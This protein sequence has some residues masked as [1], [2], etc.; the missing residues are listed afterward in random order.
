M[1]SI[2]WDT[3]KLPGQSPIPPSPGQ[4]TP[5]PAGPVDNP[6]VSA[7]V[8]LDQLQLRNNETVL[9]RVADVLQ[10]GGAGPELVLDIRGRSLLVQ[11]SIGNS[12][13][14]VGDW[15]RI[16][17]AGNELQLL[18]KL[19]Q[20]PDAGIAKALAQRLPWQQSLQTGLSVLFQSLAGGV[21]PDPTPGQLPS[22]VTATPLPEAA[23]QALSQLIARFP[24]STGV[25]PGAGSSSGAPEQVR[26]WLSESGLF[27]EARLARAQD[28]PPADL[29]LALMRV[30]ASL[31]SQQGQ[32]P[33]HFMR[34]RAASSPELL[35]APLQFPRL[36][37]APATST[38]A[39]S[40]PVNTGQLLKLLAGMLN[41]ITVNQLHSQVL[42][43]R[44]GGD[45]PA[46]TSTLLVELPWLTPQQEPRVAQLRI[47]Q[48]EREQKQ[49]AGS[50]KT[51]VSEWRLTLAMDLDE[52]GPLHFDLALRQQTVSASIW[53]EHQA[54][55]RR[56]NEQLPLLRRSLS[57]LGLEVTELE[58][59][60]G[61]PP[62]I[63]TRL[64]HRLVDT[65]A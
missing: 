61:T 39:A 58:C 14:A 49:Q 41:R 23:R 48:H 43:A 10:R 29:K 56:V 57:E 2:N 3:M 65:R 28:A 19:A 54:T 44:A 16:A 25:A 50:R 12:E 63:Q 62:A 59:R 6:T 18:G 24:A 45:A 33:E 13:V 53:A 36:A 47:E 40:D 46:P 30:V 38:A 64:E 35:Q 17:R 22:A 51:P 15:L 8:L 11:A 21:R 26:Q 20:T 1:L 31:L 27:A 60:R 9:A 7:R 34:L 52:A 32:G 42:T 5:Q 4:P 37:S 55:L